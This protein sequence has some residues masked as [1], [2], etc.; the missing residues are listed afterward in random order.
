MVL[1]VLVLAR[2]A[3]LI[4]GI[5]EDLKSAKYGVTRDQFLTRQ[6]RRARVR[7]VGNLLVTHSQYLASMSF[8][9]LG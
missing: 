1:G 3:E 8:L 4:N 7:K 6:Q 9:S 2:S 5:C